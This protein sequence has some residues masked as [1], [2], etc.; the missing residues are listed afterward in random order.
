MF[1][2]DRF[3]E[4]SFIESF[5]LYIGFNVSFFLLILCVHFAELL[6]ESDDND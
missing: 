1:F 4:L 5:L 6:E 3:L 2:V